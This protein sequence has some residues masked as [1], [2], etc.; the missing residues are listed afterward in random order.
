MPPLIDA[1]AA[2]LTKGAAYHHFDDKAGLL[3]RAAF[4]EEQRPVCAAVTRIPL[5]A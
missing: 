2:G 5:D 3:L 4:V 1:I